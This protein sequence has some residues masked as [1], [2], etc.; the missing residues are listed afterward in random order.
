MKYVKKMNNST[1]KLY[2]GNVEGKENNPEILNFNKLADNMAIFGNQGVGKTKLMLSMMEQ[3]IENEEN[4]S[5]IVSPNEENGK[6]VSHIFESANKSNRLNDIIYISQK[7]SY[8]KLNPIYGLNDEDIATFIAIN[9]KNREEFYFMLAYKFVIGILKSFKFIQQ[10]EV[11]KIIKKKNL[12]I[13]Y[14]IPL[15]DLVTLQD[16]VEWSTLGRI[17]Y[18]DNILNNVLKEELFILNDIEKTEELEF[19]KKEALDKLKYLIGIFESEKYYDFNVEGLFKGLIRDKSILEL[20][21]HLSAVKNNPVLD[22]LNSKNKSSIIIIET[23][24][25]VEGDFFLSLILKMFSSYFEKK[26][27]EEVEKKS[28]LFLFLDE[29][30]LLNSNF[31]NLLNMGED[32]G[33]NVI[34]SSQK[35]EIFERK[36]NILDKFKIIIDM[37]QSVKNSKYMGSKLDLK[38]DNQKKVQ[39]LKRGEFYITYDN[40]NQKLIKALKVSEADYIVDYDNLYDTRINDLYCRFKEVVDNDVLRLIVKIGLEDIIKYKLIDVN[41]IEGVSS[42]KEEGAIL[43]QHFGASYGL[44]Q[45]ISL[46]E[47]V[48]NV[49]EVSLDKYI[50]DTNMEFALVASLFLYFKHVKDIVLKNPYKDH[51]VFGNDFFFDYIVLSFK[52]R[53]YHNLDEI[54]NIII[55]KISRIIKNQYPMNKKLEKD[56]EISFVIS[57]RYKARKIEFALLKKETYS[58]KWFLEELEEI[59]ANKVKEIERLKKDELK[60][61]F[62]DEKVKIIDKKNEETY[63]I[64][65]SKI[66]GVHFNKEKNTS[67]YSV[68]IFMDSQKNIYL[69][70]L[71]KKDID[72]LIEKF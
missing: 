50:K 46:K 16:I 67:I 47:H 61:I 70:N 13:L 38:I 72:L 59:K 28:K 40:G 14:D 65:L 58:T 51:I 26:S 35:K 24:E 3:I 68:E 6:T 12:S 56:K 66:S 22:R 27:S 64:K 23:N 20:T 43:V 30:S 29:F 21:E 8:M 1:K 5:F 9:V 49:F 60:V 17:Q 63:I 2:T 42:H 41:S 48:L 45:N 19:M 31:E 69:K 53:E 10:A 4:V 18:L 39:N 57:S 11:Q 34:V 33:L 32:V 25:G 54:P 52:E 15:R 7:K 44:F 36:K 55:E 71:N 62:N 37:K